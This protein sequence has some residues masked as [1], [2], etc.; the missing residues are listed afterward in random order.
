MAAVGPLNHNPPP[1]M[2][3]IYLLFCLFLIPALVQAQCSEFTLTMLQGVQRAEVQYKDAKIQ[4]FGFDLHQDKAGQKIYRKCWRN[5]DVGQVI[6]EQKII[7]DP[8]KNTIVFMTLNKEHF[9]SLR[10]SI[11]SRQHSSGATEDPNVYIGRMFEY[12]FGLVSND[13]HE[14]YKVSIAFL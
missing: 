2:R 12:H 6:Y 3:F 10:Q 11:E 13:G 4:S 7:W 14:Y 5:T 8:A 9:L 1:V